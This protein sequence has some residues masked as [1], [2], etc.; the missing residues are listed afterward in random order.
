M[1][2]M[3]RFAAIAAAA[4]MTACMAV[5]MMTGFAA[6]VADGETGNSIT[7]TN[8]DGA[9][10]TYSAYQIFSGDFESGVLASIQWGDGV[11]GVALLTALQGDATIGSYFT[12]DTSAYDVSVGLANDAFKNDSAEA[13][14]F[15]ELV[16]A[17]IKTA[18]TSGNVSGDTIS[19]LPDGYYLILDSAA[20]TNPGGTN[21]NSGA[22]TR[23]VVRVTDDETVTL[24][25][26]H[27]APSVEKKVKENVKYTGNDGYGANYN[28]VADW[29]IG[30]AVPF[31]LYGTL[32]DTLNSYETYKYIFHDTLSAGLD[33]NDDAKVWL[34]NTTGDPADITGE[35]TITEANGVLTISCSDV[36]A[37]DGVTASSKI[38]V[39][40]TATLDVDAEIGLDGNPNQVYLEYSNNPNQEGSG[41]NETGQTPVDKVIVF[42]YELDTT[43]VDAADSTKKLQNA[44]FYLKD[45]EGNYV[46]V[47][48]S[49]V[50]TGWTTEKTDA[51]ELTSDSNGLFK[52]IGLDDGTYALQEVTPPS[53]YNILTEDVAIVITAGT[54][55]NQTWTGTA[56]D[57]LQTLAVSVD[58]TS[59]DGNTQSGIV[60]ATVTNNKGSVLPSTGG[61]GTTL[62]YVIGGT[63]AAGAGVALIAKKRM[64][65]EE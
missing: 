36:T 16:A 52:V 49:G 39:E 26:K 46:Q 18:S 55:H 28:D 23:Y 13:Q 59:A 35:F 63:L 14:K 47:N 53:G 10:H 58:G 31:K 44:V 21:P 19:G 33:Y 24:D 2:K 29:T 7:L 5:P 60:N 43:K 64:K 57:A 38:Q 6:K 4:A 37:I 50:V 41:A 34:V 15:A 30:D 56:G 42:T 27:S 45:A 9:T 48:D 3:R 22:K 32:P 8:K 61:I 25:A 17:N 40:Y 20:P 11:D 51:S 62:F 1:K 65:N 54:V 12:G